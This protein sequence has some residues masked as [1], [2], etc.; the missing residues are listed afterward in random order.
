VDE[1]VIEALKK[2]EAITEDKVL[3]YLVRIKKDAICLDPHL[4]EVR[5]LANQD[6]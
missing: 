3:T 4:K 1:I 6:S 5:V 2:I